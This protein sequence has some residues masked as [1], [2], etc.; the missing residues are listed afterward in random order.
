MAE[1]DEDV[2]HEEPQP[3]VGKILE[4]I[5]WINDNWKSIPVREKGKMTQLSEV[6]DQLVAYRFV[7]DY[8]ITWLIK[9]GHLKEG[10]RLR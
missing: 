7:R 9:K 1:N 8:L 3:A 10:Q 2:V 4:P 5:S 6:E